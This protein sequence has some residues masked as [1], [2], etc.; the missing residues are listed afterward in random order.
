MQVQ[1]TRDGKKNVVLMVWGQAED[2]TEPFVVV[3]PSDVQD[4]PAALKLDQIQ[5]AVEKDARVQIGFA[6]D[7][8]ILPVEGRGLL[9]YYQFD[10]IQPSTPGQALWVSA[11]GTGAFH[12]VLD[13]TK[14]ERWHE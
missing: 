1:L 9:N 10:S 5:F 8:L 2:S 12:L 14:M 7:G 11:T 13:C 4:S 3:R 6:D